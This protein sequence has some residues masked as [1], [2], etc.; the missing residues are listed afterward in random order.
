MLALPHFESPIQ[1]LEMDH[2]RLN[3]LCGQVFAGF[4]IIKKLEEEKNMGI[5]FPEIPFRK[6]IA[7]LENYINLDEEE[8]LII[9]LGIIKNA[10]DKFFEAIQ[11]RKLHYEKELDDE[12]RFRKKMKLKL[13]KKLWVGLEDLAKDLEDV[14]LGKEVLHPTHSSFQFKFIFIFGIRVCWSQ[15]ILKE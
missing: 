12:W 8:G 2:G 5:E 15:K 11:S 3:L 10:R 7:Q 6:I 14:L 13:R 1:H 4:K 9:S